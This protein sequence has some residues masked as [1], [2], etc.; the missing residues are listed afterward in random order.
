MRAA[1]PNRE[2]LS[3]FL[4]RSSLTPV[5]VFSLVIAILMAAVSIAGLVYGTSIYPTNALLRSFVPNDVVNLLIGLPIV[6]GSME[7]ARRGHLI[8][9]IC[10][11]GA[12]FYV[13]YN[14]LVYVFAMP[15]NLAFV[16]HLGLVTLSLYTL[17]GLLTSIDTKAVQQGLAGKVHER[18]NGGILAGLGLVFLLRV[19]GVMVGALTRQT[20]MAE[21]ELAVNITD[22]LVT[23]AW[24]VG[25]ILLWQRRAFGYVAGLGLL[26][27][28]SMLFMG[29][30]AF[31][32]L[33][34]ILTTAPFAL[35]DVVVVSIMGLICFV[36]F[37]LSVRG[38]FAKTGQT[39]PGTR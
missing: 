13:V 3:N 39:L 17:V 9:L 7:L 6:L 26:F 8:G 19:I 23:P 1:N 29:L 32:L 11:P 14:Y 15:L 16:L 18:I 4:V 34:P 37:G 33:Q 24:I 25:G 10:W 35:T 21:T 2:D 31:L 5:Y 22:F 20:P 30:I 12:L 27:Q 38:V 28:A 36:P